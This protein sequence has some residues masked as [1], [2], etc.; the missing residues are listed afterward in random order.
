[1]CGVGDVQQPKPRA[2]LLSRSESTIGQ[3]PSLAAIQAIV[4]ARYSRWH[5]NLKGEIRRSTVLWR[6]LTASDCHRALAAVAAAEY[7]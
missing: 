4:G 5:T 6:G 1:M 2:G 3:P 7:A